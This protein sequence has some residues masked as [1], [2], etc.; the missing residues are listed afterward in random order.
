MVKLHLIYMF[1]IE[2]KNLSVLCVASVYTGELRTSRNAKRATKVAIAEFRD[3]L[4]PSKLPLTVAKAKLM[5][6]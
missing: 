3:Q 6:L 2:K 4:T 1:L 5:F